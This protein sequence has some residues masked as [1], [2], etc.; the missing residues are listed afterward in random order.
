MKV[1]N[2]AQIREAD[3]Y[4]IAHEPIASIDLMERASQAFLVKFLGLHPTKQ[5]VFIFCGTGNNGGDGLAISR[6]LLERGWS[7]QIFV[8]GDVDKGSSDFVDNLKRLNSHHEITDIGD[9]PSIPEG[10]IIIDAIFG[11]GLTRPVQGLQAELITFLNDQNSQ[12]IAVDIA[13][14]LY[15]DQPLSKGSVVFEPDFTISFHVPK[16]AFFQP[17][18]KKYVGQWRNVDIG[19][20]EDFIASVDSS[21][22]LSE[23]REIQRLLPS[24]STFDH[25]GSVGRLMI[26]A[27]SEGKM[28][29]AVLCARAAFKAGVGLVNV[30]SPRCGIEIL[31]I[32]IPEAMVS[33]DS[34]ESQI[35]LIPTT[36]DAI[37]IGPGIG[38]DSSTLNALSY[39]LK[40]QEDPIVVDADGINLISANPN[41][42]DLLPKESILTPHPGEFKRL[43]GEWGDDFEKLEKL[44][45]YCM[46]YEL[47]IVLKGAYSAVCSSSGG[48]HFNSTGNP[49]LATAGSGDVLTGI[50]G[51]FL[52]QGIKPFDA[53]RLAVFLH[54]LAG[55][56][57][58]RSLE[59][60]WIQAS[61]II[62]FM[63][64]AIASL[65]RD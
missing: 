12:R 36:E 39:F 15:S 56:E 50:T 60:P 34:G 3:Q 24:R 64:K 28:G 46:K 1:L 63:P 61:D 6:L 30:H 58:V 26:V 4:T 38:T 54:G 27:G 43:V 62:D 18:S 59:S 19:L 57:A 42:V 33:L 65:A 55:D 22:Y 40:A 23:K 51:A 45:S 52:A 16:L 8:I 5:P 14:G 31:Q 53:L 41:L 25:K 2:A 20:S 47:N 44:R 48:I 37:A 7:I 32:S 35:E 17:Q 11:S 29:A 21:F 9:F 49:S 10:S 13:S